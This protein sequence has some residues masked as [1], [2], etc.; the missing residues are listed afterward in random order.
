MSLPFLHD[1]NHIGLRSLFR[2]TTRARMVF[3]SPGRMMSFTPTL[4]TSIRRRARV[5]QMCSATV[6]SIDPL[7]SSSFVERACADGSAQPQLRS[8]YR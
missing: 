5:H 1:D 6:R 3:I 7:S 4:A 8:R 2:F